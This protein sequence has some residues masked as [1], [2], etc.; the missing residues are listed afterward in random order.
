MRGTYLIFSCLLLVACGAGPANYE[1]TSI[2]DLHDQMQ[3]G[4]LSS[5]QLVSWYLD[6]IEAIDRNGPK[7]NAIIELNP[8]ALLIARAL[9]EH[10]LYD[11]RPHKTGFSGHT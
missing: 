5:E 11:D 8:D 9:D 7:L 4:E 6:R 1:E 3:R 10:P 2:A